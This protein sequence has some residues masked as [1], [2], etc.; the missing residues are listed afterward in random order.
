MQASDPKVDAGVTEETCFLLIR[1]GE[2]VWNATGCWQGHGDP[3]LSARGEEQASALARSL[4]GQGVERLISSDLQRALQTAAAIGSALGLE[5]ES[6][7]DLRELD[8]SRWTGLTRAEIEQREPELLAEFE[9]EDPDVRPG[10]G[11]SRS[12]LRTRVR[13]AAEQLASEQPGARIAVVA[14]LGVL[15]ALKPGVE[16][17]HVEI[18]ETSLAEI[19]AAAAAD[20]RQRGLRV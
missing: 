11:E 15:R 13:A 20:A 10:G 9:G 17:D 7:A 1:H 2:S 19:R 6:R 4:K 12:E 8:V 5:V 3:P 16:P 18:I 14:H